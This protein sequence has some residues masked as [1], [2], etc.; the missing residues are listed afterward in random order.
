MSSNGAKQT[1]TTRRILVLFFDNDETGQGDSG[2]V[3]NSKTT[4]GCKQLLQPISPGEIAALPAGDRELA[5]RFNTSKQT[6]RTG[7][8]NYKH[9]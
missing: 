6:V 3:G 2:Y 1:S 9:H 7:K 8:M 4:V 5:H